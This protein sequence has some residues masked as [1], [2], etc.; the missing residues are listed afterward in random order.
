MGL[1]LPKW[2]EQLVR[3]GSIDGWWGRCLNGSSRSSTR[4]DI[5]ST[6]LQF[7]FFVGSPG[8]LVGGYPY[9]SC[10]SIVKHGYE[11]LSRQKP[12]CVANHYH[13]LSIGSSLVS[14]PPDLMVYTFSLPY[15]NCQ[16][17]LLLG[18]PIDRVDFTG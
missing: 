14:H 9:R 16:V 10:R 17:K 4:L 18:G 15:Q 5:C 3:M 12:T 11:H 2:N 13:T 8:R 7:S 6:S 1:T